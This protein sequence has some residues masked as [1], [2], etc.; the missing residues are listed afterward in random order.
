[1]NFPELKPK[2]ILPV[3]I[4][5]SEYKNTYRLWKNIIWYSKNEI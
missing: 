1:M 4:P 5:N 3:W 2:H